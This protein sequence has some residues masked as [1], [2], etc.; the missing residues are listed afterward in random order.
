MIKTVIFDIDNTLYSYDRAHAAAFPKLLAYAEKELGFPAQEFKEAYSREYKIMQ[1]QLG[2]KAA[3]HNRLIR[4]QRVLEKRGLPLMPHVLKMN[5]LYWD[6][7]MDAMEP[8]PHAAETVRQLKDAGLCLGV[9]TDMTARVQLQKLERLGLLNDF[10]FV[11]SSE[12]AGVEKPSPELFLFCA[13]K[14]GC[15]PE[16][17]LFVGDNR[18]KDVGGALAAG[19]SA[20]WYCPQGEE[21]S[22]NSGNRD[23]ETVSGEWVMIRDL[24]EIPNLI[25]RKMNADR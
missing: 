25:R 4:I 7:L 20:A 10:D 24:A 2:E 12:E 13:E 23:P 6:S 9:G 14:A 11:V 17:C 16:E 21:L 19:M 18:K 3:I 15:M 8:S 5:D 1:A 22:G